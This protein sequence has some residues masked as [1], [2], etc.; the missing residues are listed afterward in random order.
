MAGTILP[1]LPIP[2]GGTLILLAAGGGYPDVPVNSPFAPLPA[3]CKS[4]HPKLPG[5]TRSRGIPVVVPMACESLMAAITLPSGYHRKAARGA[6]GTA[7]CGGG[8]RAAPE[9]AGSEQKRTEAGRVRGSAWRGKAIELDTLLTSP[10]SARFPGVRRCGLTTPPLAHQQ[11]Q[12]AYC[13]WNGRQTSTLDSKEENP[14][15]RPVWSCSW[16]E[17]ASTLSR[18]GPLLSRAHRL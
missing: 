4:R 16:P 1:A 8:I 13:S 11:L 6:T 12:K 10:I 3:V 9:A 17:M 15:G 14:G 18:Q 2:R 5:R 7:R